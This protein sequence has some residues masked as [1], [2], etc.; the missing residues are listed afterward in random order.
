ML[1]L[2]SFLF[3]GAAVAIF[4]LNVVLSGHGR[5]GFG[6]EQMIRGGVP[7]LLLVPLLAAL[8]F[9][10]AAFVRRRTWMRGAL[11]GLEAS[12]LAAFVFLFTTMTGLPV[13]RLAIGVGDAFPGYSLPDQA[14]VVHTVAA[15]APRAPALY[16]FYRGDW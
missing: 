12:T 4:A 13:H 2:W 3:L 6:Y 1:T 7:S 10:V 9:G 14:G 16:I 11:I 8:A 5:L 15:H